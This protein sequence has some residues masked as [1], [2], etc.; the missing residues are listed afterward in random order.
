M[1]IKGYE[2]RV[3]ESVK[4][5]EI[6]VASTNP[7]FRRIKDAL[8]E[9]KPYI[10]K[11]FKVVV[12]GYFHRHNRVLDAFL[13][14]LSLVDK[15]GIVVF[16]SRARYTRRE[17]RELRNRARELRARGY[18]VKRISE[19]LKIPLKTVYRWVKN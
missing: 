1:A 3:K 8:A 6:T 7:S 11:G 18:T 2:V 15:E 17:R 14:A 4:V 9:V 13:F 10:T 16:E 12:R 5:I 19:E